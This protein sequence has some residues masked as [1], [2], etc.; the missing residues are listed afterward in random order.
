MEIKEEFESEILGKIVKEPD[1]KNETIKYDLI[2]DSKCDP[3]VDNMKIKVEIGQDPLTI[4]EENHEQIDDLSQDPLDIKQ[5][6]KTEN[7]P[8]KM[9]YCEKCRFKSKSILTITNHKASCPI[10]KV[11]KCK[12]CEY[13]SKSLNDIKIHNNQS[14]SKTALAKVKLKNSYQKKK[15]NANTNGQFK[16]RRCKFVG[17][18][19]NQ[20]R[21]HNLENHKK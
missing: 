12:L 18:T 15:K 2:S 11:Y 8:E 5:E 4:K 16:C 13:Q 20:V 9:Y 7:S 3:P 14:H 6:S 19:L 10:E 21:V 17:K 1:P